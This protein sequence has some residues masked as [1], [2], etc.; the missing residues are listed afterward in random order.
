MLLPPAKPRPMISLLPSSATLYLQYGRPAPLFL[1]ACA[2]GAENASC[3]AVAW[4]EPAAGG[5]QAAPRTDL[6]PYLR[7]VQTVEC[8]AA[9]QV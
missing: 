7:V 1:G 8:D 3:G 9:G 4:D 5:L 6:T 2:S